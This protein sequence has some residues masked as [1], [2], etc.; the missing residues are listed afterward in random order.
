MRAPQALLVGM[1]RVLKYE[2][3]LVINFLFLRGVEGVSGGEGGDNVT[4][5]SPTTSP[6]RATCNIYNADAT[7]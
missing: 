6:P 5:S 2:S 7:R 1:K 4:V 3:I